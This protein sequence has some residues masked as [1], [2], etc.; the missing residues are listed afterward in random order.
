MPSIAPLTHDYTG[1][2][3]EY[4]NTRKKLVIRKEKKLL[5]TDNIIIYIENPKPNL[6]NVFN[7]TA[8]Y[9]ANIQ[10]VFALLDTNNNLLG[11][12][13]HSVIPNK[14]QIGIFTELNL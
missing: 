5:F 13:V 9:S 8:E 1:G 6:I 4:N 11:K 3:K 12:T 14:V 10:K 7:K 2:P